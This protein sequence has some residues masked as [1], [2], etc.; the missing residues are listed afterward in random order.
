VKRAILIY[1]PFSGNRSIKENF[2]LI[3]EKFQK[4]NIGIT[5]Y[6][7][8]S[9]ENQEIVDFIKNQH[10][11]MVII[12]GG[13][14]TINLVINQLKKNEINIPIGLIPTGTCNDFA[15]SI[16]IPNNIEESIDT[17]LSGKTKSFDLGLVNKEHYFS[18]TLA[19]GN[20]VGVSF[21]THDELKKNFGPFAYYLKA[22]SE[23]NNMQYT[24]LKIET[25]NEVIID[26]VTLFL[27]L[28]GRQGAGF[29]NLLHTADVSD[30][31]M[32]MILIKKSNSIDLAPIFFKVLSGEEL[33]SK[34]V[35][36]CR[37]KKCK[38]H[39]EEELSVS[40]DGE[41][42]PSLPLEIEFIKGAINV[43]VNDE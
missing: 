3:I 22:L 30:G 36:L 21:A 43:F 6:R 5:F 10:I 1:N 40:I 41:K 33:N 9:D 28:N 12:S 42:G 29:S 34:K 39:A 23:V 20:F 14:G 31:Y 11:D 37:T 15:S 24:N 25:D 16:N 27:I 2:D 13:D 18:S 7:L 32:D 8:Y 4:K 38:I 17:I 26:E 35:Y 19:G